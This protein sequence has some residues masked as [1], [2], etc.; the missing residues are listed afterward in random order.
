MPRSRVHR[1]TW[2]QLTPDETPGIRSAVAPTASRSVAATKV[3]RADRERIVRAHRQI[4]INLGLIFAALIGGVAVVIATDSDQ[5]SG[6]I[7]V[8]VGA[9]GGLLGLL[10]LTP[11]RR[12]LRKLGL[13]TSDAAKILAQERARRRGPV[14]VRPAVEVRHRGRAAARTY[15]IVGAAGLITGLVSLVR[16]ISFMGRDLPEGT[17]VPGPV[18]LTGCWIPIGLV[19]GIVLLLLAPHQF[20]ISRGEQG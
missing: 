7:I 8:P 9:L 3:S 20:R 15:V 1:A 11:E 6:A 13:D 14:P 17:T 10:A 19:G 5:T 16:F 4:F 2:P 12:L 18:V